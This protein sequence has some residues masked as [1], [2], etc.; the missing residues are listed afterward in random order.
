MTDFS[1]PNPDWDPDIVEALEREFEFDSENELEDN[2]MDLADPKHEGEAGID[3]DLATH[4]HKMY[5]PLSGNAARG[6]T[7]LKIQASWRNTSIE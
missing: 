2:F 7:F 6:C 1:H 4:L 3:P 5:V